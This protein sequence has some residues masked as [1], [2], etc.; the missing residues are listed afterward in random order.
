MNPPAPQSV[1]STSGKWFR[2]W[3]VI[4]RGTINLSQ[5]SM[6]WSSM[7]RK[8]RIPVGVIRNSTKSNVAGGRFSGSSFEKRQ[9]PQWLSSMTRT[10]DNSF[11]K[12]RDSKPRV[13]LNA[14]HNRRMPVCSS[15]T[16]TRYRFLGFLRRCS[17]RQHWAWL[18]ISGSGRR[19]RWVPTLSL[20]RRS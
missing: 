14:C 15:L 18:T 6:R 5:D 16:A 20:T 7:K 17:R 12:S 8:I 3:C 1:T 9:A 19:C 4:S 13:S 11:V 2:V 10:K